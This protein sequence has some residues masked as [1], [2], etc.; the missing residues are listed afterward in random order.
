MYLNKRQETL[1]LKTYNHKQH[2]SLYKEAAQLI[3]S[4]VDF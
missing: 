3:A 4:S 2:R 1:E